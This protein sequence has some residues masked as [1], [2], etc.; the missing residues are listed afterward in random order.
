[1]FIDKL[2]LNLCFLFFPLATTNKKLTTAYLNVV[3][4]FIIKFDRFPA[5][6]GIKISD[7]KLSLNNV[8]FLLYF[9]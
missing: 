8:T 7:E 2:K 3:K 9:Y 1:M 6:R 5:Q 4:L